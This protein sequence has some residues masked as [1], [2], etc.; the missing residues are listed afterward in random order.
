MPIHT[1]LNN[2]PVFKNAV[3]TVGTFDGV[4]NGHKILIRQIID[5]SKKRGGESVLI[6]FE[7]HPRSV[8]QPQNDTLKLLTTTN[9]KTALIVREGVDHMV[10]A[11][12]TKEFSML[13]AREYIE[14]FLI[15]R[16]HPAAIV[17]GYNHQFGHHRDGNIELLMKC[18]SIYQ[19][20]VIEIHKQ[21]END[22]EVSSTRIRIALQEGD[23]STANILLGR[24]YS[25]SGIVV[26]GDQR[27]KTIGY[28]TANVHLDVEQKLIPARGVYAVI[29]SVRDKQHKGM[30]NIG[31]RPTI[32]GT[33][34]TIEAHLFDFNDDIY[35]E[36]IQVSCVS[37]IRDEIKFSSLDELKNQLHRDKQNAMMLLQI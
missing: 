34:E 24:K 18:S 31:V 1:D 19:Y 25:F 28:P 33:S 6:S 12:F 37:R 13:S 35:G 5:E 26:K 2:L 8:L 14:K 4:H 20:D 16:F 29:V 9:E 3:I 23:V 15:R 17:L 22:I 32:D 30:M 11:P 36:P 7:P 10:I 27:G 21:L